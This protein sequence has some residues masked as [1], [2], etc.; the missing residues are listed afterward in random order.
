VLADVRDT[1]ELAGLVRGVVEEF[2]LAMKLVEL[3]SIKGNSTCW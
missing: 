2:K 1:V 3:A